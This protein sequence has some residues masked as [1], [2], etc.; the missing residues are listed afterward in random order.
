MFQTVIVIEV[1]LAR[2]RAE[3]PQKS[4]GLKQFTGD[5]NRA[6]RQQPRQKLS[7]HQNLAPYG[8]EKIK[9]QTAV[10]DFASKQ[11]HENSQASEKNRQA[12]EKEL[13]HTGEHDRVLARVVPLL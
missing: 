8:R 12:K 1:N 7:H 4:D 11:V 5:K 9:V 2:A 13:E 10:K 3:V 6:S